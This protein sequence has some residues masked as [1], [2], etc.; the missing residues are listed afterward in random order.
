MS[1][2]TND[3]YC[4][5]CKSCPLITDYCPNCSRIESSPLLAQ[6]HSALEAEIQ[7]LRRIEYAAVACSEHPIWNDD[8]FYDLMCELQKA[9]RGERT[10]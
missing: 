9:L 7:R 1:A 10:L 4:P 6:Y 3:N 5:T 8:R 2:Q